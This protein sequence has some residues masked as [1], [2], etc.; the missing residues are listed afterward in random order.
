MAAAEVMRASAPG[1][2]YIF[3]PLTAAPIFADGLL[4]SH[5][6]NGKRHTRLCPKNKGSIHIGL[7]TCMVVSQPV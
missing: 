2:T 5:M 7:D 4:I 1:T 3:S 6:R